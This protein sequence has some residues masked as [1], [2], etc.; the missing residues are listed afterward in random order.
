MEK[1]P[2]TT[3][4]IFKKDREK[5]LKLMAKKEYEQGRTYTNATFFELLME[6][7]KHE[8]KP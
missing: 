6:D 3:I 1:I 4:S 8:E 7:C 2:T 5:F